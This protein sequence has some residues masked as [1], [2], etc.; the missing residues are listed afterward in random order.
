MVGGGDPFCVT[1]WFKR[2]RWSEI[3]DFEPII[4][5]SAP[6]VRPSEKSSI[7]TNR[8]SP[9]RFSR[10]KQI[11]SS[12]LVSRISA[13]NT[14]L[15]HAKHKITRNREMGRQTDRHAHTKLLQ[16]QIGAT[17]NQTDMATM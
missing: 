15:Q 8:K 14:E 13:E 16:R 1:F 5:R 10:K 4:S 12:K 17:Q 7:N 6:A 9:M 11:R 3:A 2:P